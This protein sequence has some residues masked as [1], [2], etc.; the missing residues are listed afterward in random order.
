MSALNLYLELEQRM[1]HLDDDKD[2]ALADKIRI[3][4]DGIWYNQLSVEERTRLNGRL[5]LKMQKVLLIE[6]VDR[7]GKSNIIKELSKRMRIP[8]FKASL[9]HDTYLKHPDEF[10]MQMRYAYPR[11]I[12]LLRQTKQ[13]L[14]IDRGHASERVYSHILGRK[15]DES[16]LR[17]LDEDCAELG[18]SIIVCRRKSYV[19][20]SDDIDDKLTSAVL[21][22]LDNEYEEFINWT[23]CK[24]YTLWV[25]DED[26][27]REV[28]EIQRFI[29]WSDQLDCDIKAQASEVEE[30]AKEWSCVD[31]DG[32]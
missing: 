21:T 17:L 15:T 2:E 14:I 13:S 5:S 18:M 6:G 23:K 28:K 25:D 10:L 11:M 22:N 8:S 31:G 32:L 1:M 4:L 24:T 7:T 12:D 3:I 27:D 16:L 26:L 9:E 19:G 29:S 30:I 20:I